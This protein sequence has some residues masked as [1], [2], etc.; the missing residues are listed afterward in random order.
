MRIILSGATGFIGKHLL[1]RFDSDEVSVIAIVRK[2][3][4]I[5]W[6]SGRPC[7]TH[8]LDYQD[9]DD[10]AILSAIQEVD[11]VVH[12]A[13][14]YGGGIREIESIFLSNVVF[15]MKLLQLAVDKRINNFINIDSFFNTIQSTYTYK[16]NYSLSKKHFQQWGVAFSS[17]SCISFANVK[18][19]HVYGP[20][21]R[22]E[23]FV[24]TLVRDCLLGYDI[25]MTSGEQV[26]D[27][28]YIDD[29]V[30]AISLVAQSKHS[31]GYS[32]YNVGS[33]VGTSIKSFSYLLNEV[34]GNKSALIFGALPTR[35]GEFTHAVADTSSLV[36]LGWSCRTTLDIGLRLTV[37]AYI[38]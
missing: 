26:R 31:I 23:K 29:V 33:G 17:T 38:K 2:G 21:D 35:E 24:P 28:V 32:E 27:F 9:A 22:Q 5:S 11:A 30:N 14:D 16:S 36:A 34:C 8:I 20:G 7:V 13:T 12:A 37:S 10:W 4:D 6:L 15:P 19:F 18:L 25:K 1:N 3:S